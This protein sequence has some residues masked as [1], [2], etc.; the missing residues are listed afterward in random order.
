MQLQVSIFSG[1]LR[2]AQFEA[3][4]KPHAFYRASE[5]ADA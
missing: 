1:L 2:D 4:R 5:I 3:H